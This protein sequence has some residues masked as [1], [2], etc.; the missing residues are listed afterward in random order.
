MDINEITNDDTFTFDE[1][2]FPAYDAELDPI[3]PTF[4]FERFL[5]EV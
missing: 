3:S 4:S 5:N 1:N 2:N